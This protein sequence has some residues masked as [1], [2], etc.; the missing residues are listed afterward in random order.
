MK[1][2][3]VGKLE[4]MILETMPVTISIIQKYF[5]HACV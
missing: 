3:L 1:E 5:V 4:R 2:V